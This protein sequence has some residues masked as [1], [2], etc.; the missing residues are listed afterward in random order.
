MDSS[1]YRQ[2]EESGVDWR[3]TVKP[4]L[5]EGL[6]EPSQKI[7]DVLFKNKMPLFSHL[8]VNTH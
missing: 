8:P 1:V 7:T 4:F 6:D 2:N 5:K 3:T